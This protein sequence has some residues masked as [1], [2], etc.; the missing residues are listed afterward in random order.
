MDRLADNRTSPSRIRLV[1]ANLPVMICDLLK[2]A[3]RAIPDI[4]LLEPTND[5]RHLLD[6]SKADSADVILLGSARQENIA[7]VITIMESLPSRYAKSRVIVLTQNSDYT[8]V[9]A[10]FRSGA[11]GLLNSEDLNFDLL[12]KSIRCVHQGEIWANNEQLAY[13][14]SSLAHPRSREVTDSY[15]KPLLTTREQQVLHLLAEGLS[16]YELAEELKLSEH[17]IKNHLFRIYDKLGVST[18]MEAVLYALT[19]RKTRRVS[20]IQEHSSKIRAIKA[21]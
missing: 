5:V 12:C 9:I 11:R 4:Y 1:I 16:N 7:S 8:E 15:G 14:V 6:I 21:S 2:G 3:L 13:L 18:R 10:L 19:P 20:S 17:T